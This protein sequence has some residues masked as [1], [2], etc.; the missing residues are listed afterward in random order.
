MA[1]IY[2]RIFWCKT[3]ST[4]TCFCFLLAC[5]L[6]RQ[7]LHDFPMA[8]HGIVRFALHPVRSYETSI[9]RNSHSRATT[10]TRNPVE[11]HPSTQPYNARP[12]RDPCGFTSA[13][14]VVT[15]K[16]FFSLEVCNPVGMP[17]L[18]ELPLLGRHPPRGLLQLRVVTI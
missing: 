10:Q 11:T 4:K 16:D 1:K 17:F 9:E 12:G 8:A 18:K 2:S 3:S 6:V 13:V 14:Q 7:T 15:L 5:I